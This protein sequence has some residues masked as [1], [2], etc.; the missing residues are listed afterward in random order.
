MADTRSTIRSR[1]LGDALRQAM[2][3]AGLNG[4][5]TAKML[6]WSESRVSRV[7]NG[8][9]GVNEVD[10]SAF[11]ALCMVTGEER[12]RLLRLTREGDTPG[13]LQQHGSSMP[14]Q[15][16]TLIDHES[17]AVDINEFEPDFVP[18][19]LQTGDYAQSLLERSA[20][21]PP[22]EVQDRV[23]ARL[24]RQSLFSKERRPQFTFYLH[25]FVLRLPVGGSEV[26]SDQL[27]SLLRMAVRSYISIRVIPAAYGAHAGTSGS[28]RLMEFVDFR[29]VAYVEEQTSGHFLED[30]EEIATYR[31]IFASFANCALDE[32]QSKDLIARLAVD[33]YADGE[34]SA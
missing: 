25:E 14:E 27:H 10:I 2:E 5:Q 31:K 7:L 1:E 9:L 28:C 23:A 3:R 12:E 22:S 8:T 11:L 13:W 4:K 24:A 20:T 17:K 16:K 34:G 26:M 6:G 29:P 19:L 21:I 18:G 33:L 15:L 32:G 30:P